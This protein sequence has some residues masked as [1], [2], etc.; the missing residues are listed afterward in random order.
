MKAD[1]YIYFLDNYYY[2]Q[3]V[4]NDLNR[5]IIFFNCDQS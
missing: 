3:I 4:S 2:K 1:S 5:I